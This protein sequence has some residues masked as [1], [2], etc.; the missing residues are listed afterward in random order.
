[1]KAAKVNWHFFKTTRMR[2]TAA[3]LTP[4]QKER[5]T[6]TDKI[7]KSECPE[8]WIRPPMHIWPKSW[9]S[10]EDPVVHVE[11]NLYGHFLAGLLW[12][13]HFEKVLLKYGWRKGPNLE[14]SFVNRE[15]G[16]FLSMYVDDIKLAG[17]T[18]NSDPMWKVLMKQIDLGQQTSFLDH[19]YLGCVQ[20]E[21][22]TSKDNVD[23]YRNMFESKIYVGA[24]ENY[25]FQR[26]RKQQFLHGPLPM[27]WKVMQ[28]SAW[29]DIANWQTKQLDSHTKLQLHALMV[30]N[31]K[32]EEMGSVGE[33]CKFWSQISSCSSSWSKRYGEFTIYQHSTPEVCVTVVPSDWRVD[34]GSEGNQ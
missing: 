11:R 20:R 23:N 34:R 15:K 10:V 19:V 29:K 33:L 26:N 7:P 6:I 28:R 1:M 13:R 5:C 8:I 18:E 31:S 12:D 14:C 17:K 9:S 2:R 22:Q 4:S 32:E 21:C 16:P 30:I 24:L 27:T 3:G 25:Q